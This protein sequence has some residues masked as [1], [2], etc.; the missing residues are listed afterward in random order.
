[1]G[2]QSVLEMIKG[3]GVIAIMRASSPDQLIQA[4]EA[5]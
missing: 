1:M 5:I 4:A 3:T 2:S